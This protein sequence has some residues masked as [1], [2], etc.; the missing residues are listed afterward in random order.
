MNGVEI[1]NIY[2]AEIDRCV[3]WQS[4]Y[5]IWIFISL[6]AGVLF[7][8][9]LLYWFDGEPICGI[10]AGFAL[11]IPIILATKVVE[12]IYETHY[13]VIIS[14][15]VSLTEFNE[16]YEIIETRGKIY[17]VRERNDFSE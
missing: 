7:L 5:L 2:E 14:D 8:G 13:D 4:P 6:V 12:P 11:V 9:V 10:F 16:K 17:E 3:N 1:L 15:E